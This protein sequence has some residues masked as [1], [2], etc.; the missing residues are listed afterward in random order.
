M[1]ARMSGL[2]PLQ[3]VVSRT[4]MLDPNEKDKDMVEAY[5]QGVGCRDV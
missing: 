5:D 1:V 2:I 3:L 4:G